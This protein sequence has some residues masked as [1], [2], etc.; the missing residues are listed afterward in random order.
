MPEREQP[1]PIAN[2][3]VTPSPKLPFTE[4]GDF[5]ISISIRTIA[6]VVGIWLI[7]WIIRELT[8]TLL[9]FASAIL[10]ATAIDEP[11]SSLQARGLPRSLSILTLFAVVIGLLTLVVIVLIPLVTDEAS[12]L[13]S[14]L[15]GYTNG[16]EDFLNKHG[17]RVHLADHLDI[18]A[19]VTRISDNIDVVASNL[20]QI[21]FE[22]SHGAVLIFALIVIAFMLA[23]NPTAGSRFTARF[24]NDGAHQRLIKVSGDI[25]HRIGGWVRGQILVA[26]TFGAAFGLGLWLIGIPYATSLG[27]TAGVLEIV[28]YLGGA[29]TLV[30]AVGI[31]LS[32]GLPHALAVLVLYT[33]LINIESHILAPKFIGEAVG[34]PSVVVL[35]A[36]L[37]GLEWKGLLGVL[38]AVPTVLVGAAIIDEF[39]PAPNEEGESSEP[40]GRVLDRI[41]GWWQAVRTRTG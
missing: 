15:T 18:N 30:L 37:V 33:V 26:I 27:V 31:A 38:L 5:T 25:H 28:P 40:D 35:G 22:I 41:K 6:I 39:W 17:A 19:I 1:T 16:V 21:A 12:S 7:F 13:Q 29:I 9:L 8:G 34:L 32:L 14:D 10:L 2:D 24:L 4:R 11:A 3:P 23:M 36:L 20:T